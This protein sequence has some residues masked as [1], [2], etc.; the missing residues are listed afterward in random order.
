MFRQMGESGL[1]GVTLPEEYGGAGACYVAYGLVAREVERVDS[2]YRS[3]MSVQLARDVSDL[4]LRRSRSSSAK[5]LPK[6]ARGE[7]DR[8]LRADR[9]GRRLRSRRHDDAG[10]ED[11]RRLPPHRAR[12]RGSPIRRSPTCSWSGRSRDAHDDDIRGFVLEKGMKGLSAPKIEGKLSLRASITGE[13]VMDDV[14][15]AGE[16]AAAQ[17]CGLEGSVRLPQSRALRHFVGRAG[18]GGG[19]LAR[20]RANT[21]SIAS[22]SA[23]RSPQTQLF[24]KKLADMQ[25][26]ITLGLQASPAGRAADGRGPRRPR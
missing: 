12:R 15:V 26:E 16:R 24:Q 9:A 1:L 10:R 3:M 21:A 17:R 22:S 20:A 7:L 2:G 25:T 23:G 11:R 5:Y 8:L 4:R 14:E 18:R 19:L 13:I 6:L